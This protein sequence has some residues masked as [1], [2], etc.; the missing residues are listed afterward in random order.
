MMFLNFK[1]HKKPKGNIFLN[2]PFKIFNKVASQVA[3]KFYHEVAKYFKV[4]LQELA[5]C[6][7]PWAPP[8]S[9]LMVY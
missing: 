7:V 9:I 3:E 6:W 5:S 1:E 4:D 2:S 8:F